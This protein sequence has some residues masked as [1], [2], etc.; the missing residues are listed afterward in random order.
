MSLFL[1]GG[2]LSFRLSNGTPLHKNVEIEVHTHTQPEELCICLPQVCT[3]M[4]ASAV[5]SSPFCSLSSAH[6][7]FLS[8]LFLLS[9]L[10]LL[11]SPEGQRSASGR[12]HLCSESVSEMFRLDE[13]SGLRRSV[14]VRRGRSVHHVTRQLNVVTRLLMVCWCVAGLRRSQD[15]VWTNRAL[16]PCLPTNTLL[17]PSWRRATT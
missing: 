11:G 3:D 15:K 16:R 17:L 7:S 6:C 9:L 13:T 12:Q 10:W 8:L 1:R 5:L 2:T 4:P 14:G